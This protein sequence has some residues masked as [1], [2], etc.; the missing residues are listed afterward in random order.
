MGDLP[1]LPETPTNT[2]YEYKHRD[3]TV[4]GVDA[5]KN[6]PQDGAGCGAARSLLAYTMAFPF[7]GAG[8]SN[9]IGT[10][11]C[12]VPRKSSLHPETEEP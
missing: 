1:Q 10:R 5:P 3:R 12:A 4:N 8:R 2:A 11:R 9:V 7:L 6:T